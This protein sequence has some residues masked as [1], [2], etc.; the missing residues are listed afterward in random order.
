MSLGDY[1]GVTSETAFCGDGEIVLMEQGFEDHYQGA[2]SGHFSKIV[3]DQGD[4]LKGIC[5]VKREIDIDPC[6]RIHKLDNRNLEMSIVSEEEIPLHRR[7]TENCVRSLFVR[8]VCLA[9]SLSRVP[10]HAQANQP[11][12]RYPYNQ[13]FQRITHT[14][15]D[16]IALCG[17][18]QKQK[19]DTQGMQSLLHP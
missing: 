9:V 7:C 5:L 19:L 17:S 3:S 8:D 18:C 10:K 11:S 14:H 1:D 2:G 13:I 12:S 15:Q 4:Y 16:D 6:V